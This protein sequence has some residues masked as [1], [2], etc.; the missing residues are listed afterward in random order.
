LFKDDQTAGRY[1]QELG[2]SNDSINEVA[3]ARIIEVYLNTAQL[4]QSVMDNPQNFIKRW[5]LT[6]EEFQPH[7]LQEYILET[8]CRLQDCISFES[9]VNLLVHNNMTMSVFKYLQ[10]QSD[11]SGEDLLD[12]AIPADKT[13]SAR[14][15][16]W[17]YGL[18][19]GCRYFSK[20]PRQRLLIELFDHAVEIEEYQIA[21][22]VLKY[23]FTD[24]IKVKDCNISKRLC[25]KFHDVTCYE[26]KIQLVMTAMPLLNR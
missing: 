13:I 14:N 22:R 20:Y 10:D 5:D 15:R 21:Y 17:S 19:N 3:S 18:K 4:I 7:L 11:L 1:E 12:E 23:F 6:L 16:I 24:L 8:L 9:T 26:A 2:A 25:E